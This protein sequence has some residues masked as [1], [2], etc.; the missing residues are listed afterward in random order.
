M[1]LSMKATAQEM[2]TFASEAVDVADE[3]PP[4]IGSLGGTVNSG[5]QSGNYILYRS[6]H[7]CTQQKQAEPDENCKFIHTKCM[8]SM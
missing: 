7:T 2:G 6:P 4:W 5:G 1:L 3:A 8:E